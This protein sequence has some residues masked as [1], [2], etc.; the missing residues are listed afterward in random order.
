MK[1]FVCGGAAEET[2]RLGDH[3][4]VSCGSGC[5]AYRITGSVLQL[6][7]SPGSRLEPIATQAWLRERRGAGDVRPMISTDTAIWA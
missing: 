6:L 7:D 3:V 5:G 1:C 2:A 4:P